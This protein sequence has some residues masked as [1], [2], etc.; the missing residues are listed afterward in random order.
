MIAVAEAS[1]LRG[2]ADDELLQI[3][4]ADARAVVTHNFRDFLALAAEW[5]ES[6]RR[7]GGIVLV[8]V[9]FQRQGVGGYVTALEPLLDA[10]VA[11]GTLLGR[12]T[13]LRP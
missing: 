13:W 9:G 8:P 2:R 7:H 3:A 4:A 1:V 6:G 5:A 12:I 11:E 10:G